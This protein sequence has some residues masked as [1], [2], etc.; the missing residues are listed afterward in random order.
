MTNELLI[1]RN[2][3]SVELWNKNTN[4]CLM[5][6]QLE[7]Y[8]IPQ[9]IYWLNSNLK[10]IDSNNEYLAEDEFLNYF[11]IFSTNGSIILYTT[12]STLPLYT[13]QTNSR[14][15]DAKVLNGNTILQFDNPFNL[16][17]YYDF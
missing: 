13:Y 12:Q 9:R 4:V 7:K 16:N 5:H 14:L 17:K 15:W 10:T 3:G 8:I 11:V 6:L 1:G 2:D